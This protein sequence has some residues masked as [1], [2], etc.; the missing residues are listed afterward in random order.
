[1]SDEEM[2]TIA[3][4]YATAG[5]PGIPKVTSITITTKGSAA[6]TTTYPGGVLKTVTGGNVDITGA[7]L[8]N[9]RVT[10]AATVLTDENADKYLGQKPEEIFNIAREVSVESYAG[11]ITIKFVDDK[12]NAIA[13]KADQ[14]IDAQK[15]G[16]VVGD[17]YKVDTT[18][19]DYQV[20]GY[21]YTGYTFNGGKATTGAPSGTLAK[22]A[23]TI[24]MSF[25]QNTAPV[26]VK[27]VD[28]SNSGAEIANSAITVNGVI[29]ETG[30]ILTTSDVKAKLNSFSNYI[31]TPDGNKNTSVTYGT[32]TDVT[33]HLSQVTNNITVSFVDTKGNTLKPNEIL[34][35]KDNQFIVGKEILIDSANYPIDKY[36]YQGYTLHLGSS[37]PKPESTDTKADIIASKVTAVN[38]IT[39]GFI[40]D[41]ADAAITVNF[42]DDNTNQPVGTAVPLT[43]GNNKATDI[44]TAADV[45]T[46]LTTL[47]GQGYVLTPGSA[48]NTALATQVVKDGSTYTVHVSKK[49]GAVTVNLVDDKGNTL[50]DTKGNSTYNITTDAAGNP[51]VVGGSFTVDPAGYPVSGFTYKGYKT[52]GAET[53]GNPAALTLSDQATSITLVY[54]ATVYTEE[55]PGGATDPAGTQKDYLT[56]TITVITTYTGAGKT[57]ADTTTVVTP[58]YRTATVDPKT[59]TVTY[60]GWSTGKNDPTATK[61]NLL[62]HAL[63][64]KDVAISGYTVTFGGDNGD[65][66]SEFFDAEKGT[67]SPYAALIQRSVT[68]T[69]I[70]YTPDNPGEATDPAGTQVQYLKGQIKVT[71][72]YTGA[73]S[74]TPAEKTETI[75]VYRTVSLDDQGQ[76]V[77][78]AW[79][80]ATNGL[81]GKDTD[82]LVAGLT[83]ADTVN[84][85]AI[86][87]YKA[88]VTSGSSDFT[89]KNF[90]DKGIVGTDSTVAVVSRTVAYAKDIFTPQNPGGKDTDPIGTQIEYLTGTVYVT[91]TYKGAGDAMPDST[92]DVPVAIY[93]SATVGADGKT[94][95]YGA[96]TTNEDGVTAPTDGNIVEAF[97][98]PTIN[99]YAVTTT[100]DVDAL[101]PTKLKI[102]SDTIGAPVPFTT[103]YVR[104]ATYTGTDYTPSN[105]GKEGTD[106]EGTQDEYLNGTITVNTNYKG[107]GDSRP[108]NT[109]KDVNVYRSAHLEDGKVVYTAWTTNKN[110]VTVSDNLVAAF[111]PTEITGYTV[112]TGGSTDAYTAA[113]FAT[114]TDSAG[115][116]TPYATT[117]TRTATYTATNYTPTTPGETGKDPEGTQAEYLTGTITVKSNYTGAGDA[118]PANTTDD[119]HVYRSA[120]VQDDGTVAYSAWTT[121]PDGVTA[122]TDLVDAFAPTAVKGY[123]VETSG[124]DGAYSAADFATITDAADA[125]TPY[126]TTIE[127]TAT[128]TATDYTPT[129]PGETGKDPEGTQ[130]EYLTGTIT[131]KS[132]YEGAGDATPANTTDDVKVYRSAHINSDGTV[133]YSEWT[134]NP[135]GVTLSGNLVDAFTPAEVTGYKVATSGDETA[136]TSTDFKTITDADGV[137]PPYTKT[138][139]RTAVY[140]KVTTD[141]DGGTTTTTTDPEGNVTVIDKVWPDGDKTHVEINTD[142]NVIT[143]TETP[144]GQAPLD[145][146]TVQPGDTTKTGKTTVTNNEPNGVALSHDGEGVHE[147]VTPEGDRTYSKTQNGPGVSVDPKDF[148]TTKTTPDPDGGTTTVTTNGN[149]DVTKIDKNWPD[150]DKTHAE[151]D[152]DTGV[153]T[154]TET[155]NGE[156][157]LDPVTIQPGDSTKAAKTTVDNNEPNGITMSHDGDGISETV[158]PDGT[159]N[160]KKTQNGPGVSVDLDDYYNTTKTPDPNGG[161]TTTTTDGNDKIVKIDKDWPDGDKTHIDIN[162]DTNVIT[163]TETPKGE[164]PLDPVTVQPGD[165]TKTGKTTVTNNEPGGVELTHDITPVDQDGKPTDGITTVGEHDLDDGTITYTKTQNGKGVSVDPKDYYTTK[166][167]PDPD[168]GT[169]TVTTN[170]N[171]DITKIDK[172]WP[173]GDKTHAEINTDTN[174]VTVTETPNGESPLDPVTIQ[175]GD[176]TKTGK[177]TVDNNEPNG[178][179]MS[180]DGDGVSETVNP[181]GTL[182]YVKIQ[183]GPGVSVDPDDYYNTTKTPDPNGGT[184]TTTTDGNDKIVKID[185]DWPDGDKTH[186][187]ID[188]DTNVITVTETPKGQDP[189][190]PVTVQPGDTTKTGKTTVTN[191]EPEG[192]ELTHDITPVDQDG[193]P[194]DGTTTVG[195]HDLDDGTITYTKTKNGTGVSVD[196]KDYYTTETTPDPDGGTTTVTKNGHGDVTKIDKTWPD[197]DKT[198]AEIN[199]DTNVVTVTETPNGQDPLDPVT[200]QPGDS[201]KTGKTTVDN[202]EPNGLT[203]NHDGDGVSETVNPDGTLSYAKT[204]NGPGVSVDPKDFYTTKTTPDPDGGTTTVTTDGHGDITT[205]DKTWPDGDKT[206]AEI[207][208]D[209]NVVTV[210]ETPN[211]QDPLDPVTIQPGDTAKTGKTT[212]DN[213]EPNGLTM[214]HDGDD[215]FETVH[216]DGTLSYKKTKNGPG[217]SVNIKDFTTTTPDPDGGTTTTITDGKGNIVTIDK[218]WPDGDKTHVEIN[219]DTNV[220][221][222]TETPNGE[223]P[224]DPVTVQPGDT[225]KTGKTTVTNNEPNGVAL[226]H[227]G[228]DISETVTPEGTRTYSKSKNGTGVSV[229]PKDYYTTTTTPD[230]DGGTTTVTT[231]GNGDITKIDKNWPDGDKTH[232]EIDT[233]TGVATVT[234]TPDGEQPL[235]SVTIQPGDSDKTGKTT[236]DNNEPNGITMSHDGDGISETV[237]P[238][239][240]LSYTKIQNGPGVSVNPE[241]YYDTTKTPDPDGG[242]TTTTT[243]GKGNIVKIDKDW[244]DGDKTHI[245]IDTDTNVITVTETPNGESPLDPV[246]VQPGDTTKTGKTTVTNNEPNGVELSHDGD[247]ISETIN[248]DETRTYTKTQ[249]GPGVSVDPKD[250]YTTT[251]T[252]DPDGGTTT[253]TTNGNGD[254]TK[255]DKTWPD[256]D[257]T[258]AEIDT[259]T[260]VVTVTE[261]PNGES[262]LDPVTIQP[263]DSTKTGKTTVDNNEP[264]GITMSHDGDGVSETVNPD[265]T[266]SYKKTQNGPGVS[267]DPKDY[268][269]TTTTPDPD[270]GTTTVT[271]NGNGDITTIDKN[272]PDGDKTHAEI[273]TET[274]VVTVTETPNGES[275]LDPVTIQPGDSTKTGKTTVDNNEPNGIT[276]SHDGDGVGETVNPDGTLSYKKTQNGPGVSVSPDDY[277]NTTKTP[278][279]NGGTTTTTTDGNDKIVKIDK[280]WPD[281]DKTHIDIDT[282][283]NVITVT[284]TPKGE[285]PLDP[286]TVQPGDTT[287]T[288]KTTVTNNEPGGVQLSH[289]ITPVDKDGKPT[290]GATTVGEHD[291]DDGTITYTK[292]K[293]GPGVSVDP[294]DYYDT[295]K[296]TDPNGGTTTTTT[297]GN[298][299]IVKIDKD[300]PDGDKTHIDIDTDTNVIT[301]TETP[302]GEQP[303][304]PV[305]VQPGDTTKTGKT[306]VTNNEPGGVELS[307]DITPVDQDGKPTEGTT[308][309]GEHDL[310]DGSIT[311]TKTQNGKGVSVDPKDYY[312]TTTTPD[313]DGGTTTVTTNG[314]GDITKIDKTWP[315]GDKTHAEINPDTNVVTVTETPNGEQPLAP[316]TIQPGDSTKT[317]KTTVDNNE[318][319]GLT[320]SHDGDGI[321][322]TLNPDGTLSYTKTQ[323]GPGVSVN[324]DD[325]YDTTKTPDPNGGTTTTTTDGNDKI[326][327]IDKDWP[328]GDK[329]HIDI[330]TDTNVITVTETPKGEQP[331]KPVTVQPGDTT[332]TGKTTVT[333]NEPEGVE[334]T[335]DIT[336][337]DKDGKPTDGTTTVGEHDLGDGTITYTKTKNGKGVSVDPKDYY[338]TTT[339]PDPDGGTTTVTTNGN[340]DVTKIDKIWPDGDK[341]HAEINTDT[342]VVTVT[343]TP[344]GQDPLDPVTIQPGDTTKTGKTT[345]DN[346]EPEGLTLSHDGDDISE[347]VNPDG[348]PSYKKTQNGTGVSVT[349]DDYYDTTK[350]PDPNGGITTTT[351]DGHGNIVKIDKDWPDGDKTHIDIDTDTNVITVTETPKGQDPLDPVTIQPGDTDKTGKTTVTNNE[352]NGVEL[353]HTITP[354]DKDGKPTG[355][356]TNVGEH[357]LGDGTITYTKT[358]NGTGVSVDPKDYYDTTTTPD[359]NGG[360]TTITTNGN[361]DVTKIDKNWPDGDKTH[362]EINT[363]TNVITVTETPKGQD[364]LDPVT[365][366]PGDTT[367]TGKTTVTNNE[368]AGVELTHTITPVD[369]DGKPTGE[370]TNVGEHDLSDGTITYTKTKNGTGV[371]VDPKDFYN[372]TT[373]NDPDGGTTTVTTNGN[374]DV[375]KIDKTWPDGDKTHVEINTDTNVVTVTE[376]PKGQNPL[377][378]VTIQPGDSD[379]TGKTT[380]A[381]NEPNGVTLSH[382][383]NGT[384]ET[385]NPDGTLSYKKTQNGTGVSVDPKDY[386]NTTTTKDPDGGTTTV[387]TNGNNDVTKIDKT[388]PDGDK[389]HVEINTGTNVVTVTETPNGQDPLDPVTVQPGDTTTTGKTTVTNN[390]PNGVALTHNTTDVDQNGNPVTVHDGE[391]VDHDGHITYEYTETPVDQDQNAGTD[392]TKATAQPASHK[393]DQTQQKA[394]ATKSANDKKLPQTSEAQPN[395]AAL[396]LL[397]SLIGMFGLLGVRKRRED[398]K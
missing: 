247:G 156:T 211:G 204:Q 344:N 170:G 141:P 202:N 72:D 244:P 282:D 60:S 133:G 389:T 197:G 331:L 305:T 81:G 383:G 258:H 292:T 120:H 196:P 326:V 165:T 350:A 128:Y 21:S 227:D 250:Y 338:T 391:T 40:Y 260:G 135:D 23:N 189:L 277:Y 336:P 269:T 191:N 380:V 366:Q 3:A 317:G 356:P 390:E 198:H 131:V 99:G 300:W 119:V 271:T 54:T 49:A 368:P 187:N 108:A 160:Y 193:K 229:D 176:S 234:E 143:V 296:T 207:N 30:D 214:N 144:K 353:T 299:K 166:T 347:T 155:P 177:T 316:V 378:P 255:I 357:D 136:Y 203:M 18:S 289:D 223:T 327:K 270:D 10:N 374:G 376:T 134:T 213:N 280:D 287:K 352:P 333:N 103:K 235:E 367:K 286:V 218:D 321:S 345:V 129:T 240:T 266:L 265:G 365:V 359:P 130:A 16:L 288:G 78:T 215:V 142:T 164:Q 291:L 360:T 95:S 64:E 273:N 324:P 113:D 125:K 19:T 184:T 148:Y 114:I 246:T 310:D 312:T 111:V 206:H 97:T 38:R 93:R 172:T 232:V 290:E 261:T 199:T 364:P 348:K 285:A 185:K 337:V 307:H 342:N 343:E 84:V 71:T 394:G 358:K 86:D 52:T 74:D 268:Y 123:S 167:T 41:V 375:T 7:D 12:G 132:N 220:I 117:I 384:T 168:G 32:T 201:T 70:T 362:V 216:P 61:D 4:S 243:D 79:T 5:M 57:A 2:S 325:Y 221:T 98:A 158:N 239:G 295:T 254:V 209:T 178:L 126:V 66:T 48:D 346:N 279:P 257:K 163:V 262:P 369:K 6:D 121:N 154:V 294:D 28:D 230:P 37:G 171:G 173:D 238:D 329:T 224:L 272:W 303:L 274:N 67:E 76:P 318:P 22:T 190:D 284:E 27:F 88:E 15:A 301:V 124:A 341:T 104:T 180:H 373:T 328:D 59:G 122:S 200:I 355:E 33:I 137:T 174:V 395:T 381:N 149:G 242:T 42:V 248:P 226:S 397:G 263:G 302:K 115:A 83:T 219:T 237:N 370:P 45:E 153:V 249:N 26:N 127:R 195:E 92:T 231:N 396:G 162:T 315:D 278:D 330:D 140:S 379:K 145:P 62:V 39:V 332:K 47:A 256:G 293:N 212:V 53:D 386:Y 354:V 252:P 55:K 46:E 102:L 50:K 222:V 335:H 372:T 283:T 1:M 36:M 334:L 44:L 151:I 75:N 275:P 264:N 118:T 9:G 253:V 233:N 139:N 147:T 308:T 25:V 304:D 251:T 322:E 138:L 157:P 14:T 205:I 56:G 309:V 116:T 340:G 89:A 110:G 313:P 323:N 398:D 105:P 241:D 90:A 393:A 339:T 101:T 100:G 85:P 112:T 58:V 387:T 377:D 94:V 35:A 161:T 361:G 217:V 385:V 382:D 349:P 109:S 392:T 297:D 183:N 146:V 65:Y 51:L 210:T 20:P 63:T 363:D 43:V 24:V 68:Y 298:D 188:T 152:T 311:Y 175:P 159:L 34:N 82:V 169:T 106:P 208:T 351:T 319:N 11:N 388:W 371:S 179:T 29:G 267:V 31:L 182:N 225:T 91:T 192:V 259:D 276:M 77:Y 87:G 228:D 107:G 96:W 306:T 13:G 194:T 80:T 236:V 17:T 320:M 314:N 150:G 8:G 181:D 73:G 245:E 69:P 186:I 281:G